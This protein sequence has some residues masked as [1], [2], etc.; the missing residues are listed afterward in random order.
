MARKVNLKPFYWGLSA[1]AVVG[2]GWIWVATKRPPPEVNAEP[3]PASEVAAAAAFPGYALGSDSAP[4]MVDDYSDFECPYCARLAILT[5][6]DVRSR[7][8]ASGVVR[9]RF[10][11]RPISSHAQTLVAHEAAA[12]AGEQ[13]KFWEMHDQLYYNQGTWAM[14]RDPGKQ[15]TEYAR[16]LNLDAGKF[17]DC[18][19]N[20]RYLVRIRASAQ[21]ADELGISSTPSLFINGQ[22]YDVSQHGLGYDALKS[23]IELAAQRASASKR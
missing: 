11:D 22:P 7:L 9:W 13:G 5:F 1:L 20:H 19:K 15:V 4:V 10:H 6:P 2:G 14:A 17:S 23:A 3:L 12:C 21:R 18:L 8:I 16:A